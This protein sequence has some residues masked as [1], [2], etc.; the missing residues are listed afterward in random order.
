MS[1]AMKTFRAY[2][3][4]HDRL[5]HE[6]RPIPT[7]DPATDREDCF[8]IGAYTF[9]LIMAANGVL[10]HSDDELMGEL[11][12]L[13]TVAEQILARVEKLGG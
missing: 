9:S 11:P 10:S 4:T 12:D 5:V 13:R 2:L 6:I 1:D 7:L 3:S 8:D